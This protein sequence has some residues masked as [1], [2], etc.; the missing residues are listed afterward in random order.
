MNR[1]F[2][3]DN[4]FFVF[5]GRVADLILLN[6]L[7]ILC[8][9]PI[10]TAGASI[11]SLYYV[12]LKMARDEE[13][14]IIRSFFHAFKQNFKQA[15]II[16]IIML[17]TAGVLFVDLRIARAGDSVMYK[18]LFT[19]FIAVAFI[20]ALI[21]LY[22]YPILAKFY[23]S[24]KNTFVNA[25]LMSVRHLPQTAL[26]LLISASPVLLFLLMSYTGAA[27][28][29][30]ILIMLFVLMGFATLAYWKSK[31][32]VNIF[33]NYIPKDESEKSELEEA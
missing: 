22:I 12:T 21:L 10:I 15:T 6:I 25:F 31:L 24:I 8:C 27:H 23:N 3:M 4:K 16:N 19:L 18:G 13:S 26:M 28:V 30:S 7:C 17:L 5:M 20:Y 14:Y 9:I 2:N 32:F 29:L 11:T 33:D 1:F